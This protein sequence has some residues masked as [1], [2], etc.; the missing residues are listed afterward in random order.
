MGFRVHKPCI[1]A[2]V[3]FW[4]ESVTGVLSWWSACECL[5]V[6]SCVGC[7]H[8]FAQ[9]EIYTWRWQVVMQQHVHLSC[10]Q[11]TYAHSGFP[12]SATVVWS[13]PIQCKCTALHI[14][15]SC[16]TVLCHKLPQYAMGKVCDE[17]AWVYTGSSIACW[18]VCNAYRSASRSWQRYW[19]G[20]LPLLHLISIMQRWLVL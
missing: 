3:D 9:A 18:D 12:A 17:S 14:L 4:L 13:S 5:I 19:M 16:S 1:E 11:Q 6:S 15:H 10:R 7:C 2:A 8:K 20:F